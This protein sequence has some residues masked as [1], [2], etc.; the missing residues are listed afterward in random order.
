MNGCPRV[1]CDYFVDDIESKVGRSRR[2][3]GLVVASLFV[4]VN[5]GILQEYFDYR[6]QL[7]DFRRHEVA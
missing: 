7:E 5:S 3:F 6:N 1:H 2:L 4:G